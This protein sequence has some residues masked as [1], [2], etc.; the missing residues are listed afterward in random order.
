MIKKIITAGVLISICVSAK[1]QLKEGKTNIEKLCGCF[2]IEFKY[3]ETFSPDG[4]YKFHERE[5]LYATELA[6]PIET[7]DK[8]ISIQHLLVIKDTMI[9]KHW[10]EDWTYE[11]NYLWKYEGDKKWKKVELKPEQY[12][13]KWTQTI[14]EVDDAPRYQGISDWVTTDGKTFWQSTTDAPLPRRE[15]TVRSD[16]N[17]L[18]RGNRLVLTDKGWTHEQDNEKLLVKDGS[19]KLIAQEKGYNIYKKAADKDCANAKTWWTNNVQFWTKVRAEW[20]TVLSST[21]TIQLQ[22][23]VDNKL[24]LQ[25]FDELSMQYSKKQI[26]LDE[27]SVKSKEILQ[28]FVKTASDVALK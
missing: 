28:K 26:T 22:N 18:K 3:A 12:K 27:V 10:R 5:E 14:W 7:S 25:H 20:Q 24:M 17:I 13:G 21:N 9:I 8:K 23:K 4:A 16:Y 11:Q 15:Y 19:T 6:L 2:D 1:A